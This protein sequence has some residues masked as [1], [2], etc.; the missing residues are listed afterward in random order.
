VAVGK[1][2]EG[3]TEGEREGGTIVA[4]TCSVRIGEKREGER[5]GWVF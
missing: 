5:G 3:K 4:N 2:G 1:R